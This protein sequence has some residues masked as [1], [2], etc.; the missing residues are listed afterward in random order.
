M[1]GG[2]FCVRGGLRARPGGG[3]PRALAPPAGYIQIATARRAAR[4]LRRGCRETRMA[5]FSLLV[6]M[7]VASIEAKVTVSEKVH[8]LADPTLLEYTDAGV[9]ITLGPVT[10]VGPHVP[11]SR[12]ACL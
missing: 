12:C 4:S 11:F 10:K 7:A 6:P 9:D 1:P 3:R 5:G 8:L 2:A